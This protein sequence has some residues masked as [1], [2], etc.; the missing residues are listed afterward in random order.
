MNNERIWYYLK[1][2]MRKNTER[3]KRKCSK[4]TGGSSNE[5]TFG[6]S[7]DPCS[8]TTTS[9]TVVP[10]DESRVSGDAVVPKGDRTFLSPTSTSL[11]IVTLRDVIVEEVQNSV[12]FF[13]LETDDVTRESGLN[14]TGMEERKIVVSFLGR[15]REYD[16][17]KKY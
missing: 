3:C 5:G 17:S 16:E 7:G 2:I 4:T 6:L 12:R 11:E 1:R 13:L 8:V 15:K 9:D 10:I 14:E